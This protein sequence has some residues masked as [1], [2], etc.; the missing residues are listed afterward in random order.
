[1]TDSTDFKASGADVADVN[2]GTGWYEWIR[3][4]SMTT[5]IAYVH[6]NGEVFDPEQGWN[7][8]EFLLASAA[9]RTFRLV[10]AEEADHG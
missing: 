5:H 1:M 2:S 6:E 7:S 9:G 3:E 10:R 8:P 4:G